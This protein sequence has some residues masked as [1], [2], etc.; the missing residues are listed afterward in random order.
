[1]RF[2]WS[3]TA[4]R[5][6]P[7]PL[8]QVPFV[9]QQALLDTLGERLQ[10]AQRGIMQYVTLTGPSG[11]GTSTLLDEWRFLHST[12][13]GVLLLQLNAADCVLPYEWYRQLCLG[14]QTQSE[15]IVHTVY[16]AT[17]R[18]RKTLSL[19]WDEAEFRQMLASTDWA[20][21][22]EAPAGP[23]RARGQEGNP[24][25]PLLTSVQEYPWAIGAAA[26]LDVSERSVVGSTAQRVWEQRWSTGLRTLRARFQ[27]GEAALVLLIDHLA[28]G[29]LGEAPVDRALTEAWQTFVAVTAAERL[30]CLIIWAGAEAELRPVQQV[31]QDAVYASTATTYP[32]AALTHE[33]QQQLVRR[34]V[35]A[36][37]RTRQSSWATALETAEEGVARPAWL[38]LATTCA[39]VASERGQEA[40]VPSLARLDMTALAQQLTDDIRQRHPAQAPL[41]GQL[42]EVC[43]FMPPGKQV[44]VDD[45]LPWCDFAGPEHDPTTGRT[46]LEHLLGQCVRVGLLRYDP[47]TTRYTLGSSAIQEALQA[48]LYPDALARWQVAR[49]RRLA[50]AMLQQIQQGDRTG[51]AAL[52]QYTEDTHGAAARTLLEPLLVVPFQRLLPMC[53]KEERQRMAH[54]L[55]GFPAAVT[56]DLLRF[57]I[58]DEEGQVRSSAVQSLADLGRD[59]IVPVLLEALRDRNSDVRWIATRALGQI[60][61]STAVDAL[62]PMLTDEDSE[63]GRIAA[64]GL[65]QQ[66]DRRAVPHLIAAVRESYPRLRESAILA[67]GELADQRAIPALQDVLHD[68]H[69]QVRRSAEVVLARFAAST[70]S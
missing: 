54:T 49:Q 18:V 63:V 36:L 42:L 27:T 67:L 66:G 41:L 12:K 24:L 43:A 70:G 39:A 61:G 25:A 8:V 68:A 55:G 51:L 69:Q 50:A 1:M 21:V 64:E 56:V 31:L 26:L 20:Q 62:I 60:P 5:R 48:V 40:S 14:L 57:L 17:A 10:A 22:R 65:G 16:T 58:H 53:S 52:A 7:K 59:E 38:L 23:A 28:S 2:P 33:E 45:F 35:R 6:V 34:A 47:Y 46:N 30:P 11:S 32:L 19:Q 3:S 15:Q 4:R 29:R 13:A 9:G 44:I 37:P